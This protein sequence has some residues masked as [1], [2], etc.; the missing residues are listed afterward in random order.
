MGTKR[1]YALVARKDGGVFDVKV[2]EPGRE[3]R[4]LNTFNREA[5][6]W[7]WIHEQQCV[8]QFVRRMD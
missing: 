3:P 7:E 5:D 6:A 8:E 4:V 1:S 2:A